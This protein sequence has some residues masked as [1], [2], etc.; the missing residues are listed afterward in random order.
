MVICYLEMK[1]ISKWF[2]Q[3]VLVLQVLRN[4]IKLYDF[5]EMIESGFE[6]ENF[7]LFIAYFVLNSAICSCLF[8][9]SFP[10]SRLGFV[11]HVFIN[12]FIIYSC[13]VG[14]NHIFPSEWQFHQHN[15]I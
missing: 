13:Q 7:N 15:F 11:F 9:Y 6:K 3:T 14:L 12:G 2:M 10:F 8:A 1:A 5:E 4:C